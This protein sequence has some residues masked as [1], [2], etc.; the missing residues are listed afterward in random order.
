MSMNN[1]DFRNEKTILIPADTT[2]L[3]NC[4]TTPILEEV[5]KKLPS[6]SIK[7]NFINK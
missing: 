5:L 7:N 6:S 2:Y 4:N 1:I 3:K